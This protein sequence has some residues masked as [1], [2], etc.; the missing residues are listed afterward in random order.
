MFTF[1]LIIM[2]NG[3]AI[4]TVPFTTLEACT[5]AKAQVEEAYYLKNMVKAV[6]VRRD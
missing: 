3:N 6:C 5:Q 2:L 4:T 1:I